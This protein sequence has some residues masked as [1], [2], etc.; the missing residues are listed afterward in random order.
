[1]SQ[2]PPGTLKIRPMLLG[3]VPAVAALDQ[4]SF[5]LPWP[6]RS[7]RHEVLEND[8]ARPWVAEWVTADG[9]IQ[10]A[11]MAVVWVILDEAH[12]ATFAV[13]PDF[14]RRGIGRQLLAAVLLQATGEGAT[15]SYL[16]VRRSNLAAQALYTEFGYK[17][18]G[19]RP[20]YYKD[21]FEDALLMT[22]DPINPDWLAGCIQPDT[23]ILRI[24]G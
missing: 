9:V 12:V 22:L 7:F 23:R 8:R 15:L 14:R 1:M 10:L 13:H 6:E 17:V 4:L 19:I 2:L 3:D 20:R 18:A 24:G 21:N 5:S 16:E 11:G